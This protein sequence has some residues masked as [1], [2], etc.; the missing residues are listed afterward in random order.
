LVSS[1]TVRRKQVAVWQSK[2]QDVDSDSDTNDA[3]QA[4]QS[5]GGCH[6]ATWLPIQLDKLFG[7]NL[8]EPIRIRPSCAAV[9]EESPYMELLATEHSNE[10]PDYRELEGSG[11]D[12]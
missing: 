3:L 1:P 5:A 7:S 12:Y 11:D 8:K 2:M 4:A 10:E 9:S 6:Q